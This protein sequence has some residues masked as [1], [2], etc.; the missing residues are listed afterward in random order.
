MEITDFTVSQN[1]F[2]GFNDLWAF[3][4]PV[5]MGIFEDVGEGIIWVNPPNTRRPRHQLLKHLPSSFIGGPQRF[6]PPDRV[7]GGRRGHF[8]DT[9]RPKVNGVMTHFIADCRILQGQGTHMRCLQQDVWHCYY[10]LETKPF[11]G[12]QRRHVLTATLWARK[13]WRWVRLSSWPLRSLSSAFAFEQLFWISAHFFLRMKMCTSSCL[14][15]HWIRESV[16]VLISHCCAQECSV[17]LSALFR[18]WAELGG[19]SLYLPLLPCG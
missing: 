2:P 13:A 18:R 4:Q 17:M 9:L 1:N 11:A 14:W 16:C 5:E 7:A 19:A 15:L 6:H 10:W 8:L 3:Q 12:R